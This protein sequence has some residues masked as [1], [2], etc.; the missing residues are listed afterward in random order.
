MNPNILA[1]KANRKF[2]QYGQAMTFVQ[3]SEGEPSPSTGLPT[4]VRD[5]TEFRGLWDSVKLTEL[6]TLVQVGDAV[7]WAG[8]NAIPTPDVTDWVAVDGKVWQVI[9]VE[10]VKPGAVPIC[11]RM[12]VREAG[13]AA[14]RLGA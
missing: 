13:S 9:A 3:E 7:I 12:I 8:G 1:A 2:A 6:G 5:K 11:W 14:A 4:I 10:A